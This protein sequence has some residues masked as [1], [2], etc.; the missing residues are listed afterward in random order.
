MPRWAPA[1]PE[2][3]NRE[4]VHVIHSASPP[5]WLHAG[6]AKGPRGRDRNLSLPDAQECLT[7][8]QRPRDGGRAQRGG[9][10]GARTPPLQGRAEEGPRAQRRARGVAPDAGTAGLGSGPAGSPPSE[11]AAVA[12]GGLL[13][14]CGP[15]HAVHVLR[16]GMCCR[17]GRAGRQGHA[18]SGCGFAEGQTLCSQSM[19]GHTLGWQ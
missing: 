2:P 5:S 6:P 16:P 18:R 3:R 13:A 4:P 11:A 7:R 17:G 12:A 14:A 10:A 9:A 1:G 15:S 19:R 8:G